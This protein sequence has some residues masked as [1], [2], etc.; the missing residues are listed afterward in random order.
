MRSGLTVSFLWR[1]AA[2]V[3]VFA[4]IGIVGYACHVA[5]RFEANLEYTIQV[6]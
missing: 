6:A 3:I 5:T 4:A 1:T 2:V